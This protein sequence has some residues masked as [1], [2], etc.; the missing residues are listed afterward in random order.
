M[1][2]SRLRVYGATNREKLS[3]L[4]NVPISDL[5]SVEG[6]LDATE[7]TPVGKVA[8][9][10]R[11]A[12]TYI[13]DLVITVVPPGQSGLSPVVLQTGLVAVGITWRCC[14]MHQTPPRWTPMPHIPH[15]F[16]WVYDGLRGMRSS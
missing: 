11:L 13:G 3:E 1:L 9:Y 16:F 4:L 14:T 10:V 6:T 2:S 7:T 8:V 12:H 5:G 15:P